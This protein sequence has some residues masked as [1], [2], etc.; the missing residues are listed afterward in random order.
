MD[1]LPLPPLADYPDLAGKVVHCLLRPDLATPEVLAGI[2]IARR[3][4]VAAVAVRPCDIESAVR[5]LEG[6]A[7]RPGS[8]VSFPH[9]TATTAAK[10]FE[11]RDLLRRGAKEIGVAVGAAHLLAREF[12]HVQTELAQIVEACHKEGA[13]CTAILEGAWLTGEL[14]VIALRCLERAEVDCVAAASGFGPAGYTVKDLQMLR[15]YLPE[16]TDVEAAGGVDT[17]EQVLAA[18]EAGASR[19]AT[20]HPAAILEEWSARLKVTG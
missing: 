8:V 4:G 9:G 10:I 15:K 14:K 13:R 3:L 17:L 19:F 7:V 6:S 12:Q 16:G 18:Y 1:P 5:H 2:Q 20:V 11:S